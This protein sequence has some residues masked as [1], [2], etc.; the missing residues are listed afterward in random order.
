MKDKGLG[1]A[2]RV[3]NVLYLISVTNTEFQKAGN[4]YQQQGS[5][6]LLSRPQT[7]QI[8]K[9]LGTD[10]LKEETWLHSY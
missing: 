3:S 5:H 2:C 9:C 4:D 8:C 6:V 7:L 10:R 1:R